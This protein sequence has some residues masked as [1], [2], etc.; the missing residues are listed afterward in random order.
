MYFKKW[1]GFWWLLKRGDIASRVAAIRQRELMERYAERLRKY[2]TFG[3]MARMSNQLEAN[4]EGLSKTNQVL[5][6]IVE[7]L[8]SVEDRVEVLGHHAAPDPPEIEARNVSPRRLENNMSR[9]P[10][11]V[12]DNSIFSRPLPRTGPIVTPPTIP[13][14][15]PY[16]IP[17][18]PSEVHPD[19]RSVLDYGT[20]TDPVRS[21]TGRSL[22]RILENMDGNS[23]QLDAMLRRMS[24]R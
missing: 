8:V 22:G 13:P 4:L 12:V 7:R 6:R 19:L 16:P 17:L 3:K 24:G 10:Q 21:P 11:G 23:E 2:G 1:K 18:P 9:P 20:H 5:D 15:V 14:N